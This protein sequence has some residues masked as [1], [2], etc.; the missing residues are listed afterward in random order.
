MLYPTTS[1]LWYC[2]YILLFH[3]QIHLELLNQEDFKHSNLGVKTES[4]T[5]L[6]YV[7]DQYVCCGGKA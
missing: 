4:H 2:F 3:I 1:E 6:R 7:K 5:P